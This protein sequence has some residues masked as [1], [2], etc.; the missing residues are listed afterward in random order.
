MASTAGIPRWT[1][2]AAVLEKTSS[3]PPRGA[4]AGVQ[5]YQSQGIVV[6]EQARQQRGS[7]TMAVARLVRERDVPL[8]LV[9]G[10]RSVSTTK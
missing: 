8:V 3:L 7:Q 4:F 5:Q 6:A 1:S 2:V 9:C 10:R